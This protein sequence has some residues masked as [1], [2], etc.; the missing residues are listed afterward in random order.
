MRKVNTWKDNMNN[1]I[2]DVFFNDE[3]LIELMLIP[4]SERDDIVQ[5]IDKYF[6]RDVAPDEIITTENV[7]ICY[8]ESEGVSIGS[9]MV[10]KILYFDVYVKNEHLHDV[11]NDML[12]F[13]TDCICQ[14]I[15]EDL[16][17]TKYVC[18]IDFVYKD[19][20]SMY[21]RLANYTR[22]RIVFTYKISF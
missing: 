2:R 17:D 8:G 22:Q 21:T 11:D 20:F 19:D 18:R 9:N 10:N 6:I 4:S 7:R 12:K 14:K 16:T 5:F 3:E 13:R 15:K 1:V